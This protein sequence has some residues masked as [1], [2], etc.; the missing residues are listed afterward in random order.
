M[1]K[2][3]NVKIGIIEAKVSYRYKTETTID[4]DDFR[5]TFMNAPLDPDKAMLLAVNSLLGKTVTE[6][7]IL[8]EI[9][10]IQVYQKTTMV[11]ADVFTGPKVDSIVMK[12]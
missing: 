3:N 4:T 10:D 7:R 6:G 12:K 11:S 5:M 8:L 2:S 1:A 9:Q